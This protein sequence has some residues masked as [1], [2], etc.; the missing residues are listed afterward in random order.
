MIIFLSVFSINFEKH[1]ILVGFFIVIY[2]PR[3]KNE[4]TKKKQTNETMANT[5]NILANV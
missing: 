4:Q 5:A 1:T 3:Q 2:L